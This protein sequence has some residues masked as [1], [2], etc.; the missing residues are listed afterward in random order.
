MEVHV[1]ETLATT[2]SVLAYS[3]LGP[4]PKV[5]AEAVS[6]RAFQVSTSAMVQD[7]CRSLHVLARSPQSTKSVEMESTTI[8]TERSTSFARRR[9]QQAQIVSL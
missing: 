3:H 1:L 8:A 4:T 2:F 7:P 6:E 9:A 5:H